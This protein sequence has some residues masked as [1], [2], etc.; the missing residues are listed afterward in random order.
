MWVEAHQA[1]FV[2]GSRRRSGM[3]SDEA[4]PFSA[5]A[6]ARAFT[7]AN[8]GRVVGFAEMP[9]GLRSHRN[10]G[11]EMMQLT[12]RRFIAITAAAGGLPLLSIAPARADSLLRVWTG[13][14]ARLRCDPADSS[15]GPGGRGPADRGE[16]RRG[17]T[18]RTDHEPLSARQRAFAP[19]PRRRARR[20]SVRSRACAVREPPLQRDQRRRLRCDGAA[21]VGSLCRAFLPARRLARRPCGRRHR[22]GR[23]ARRPGRFGD[24]SGAAAVRAAGDGHH[25]EWHRPGLHHRPRRRVAARR[26]RGAR[27]GGHGQDPRDRR[28]PGGRP[29]VGR[30]GGSAGSRHRSPNAFR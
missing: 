18:P 15:P 14:R 7:D 16:P 26:R 23:R 3:D 1:Y 27:S 10:A 9:Q 28:T 13:N 4:I 17:G 21:A 22:R 25:S 8:G 2:I 24:R 6:A 5:A 30:T 20:S 19:Q 29:L 12:R 11:R